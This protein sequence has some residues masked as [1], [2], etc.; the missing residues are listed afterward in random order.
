MNKTLRFWLE[1]VSRIMNI[2]TER[3]NGRVSYK[4]WNP[5]WCKRRLFSASKGWRRLHCT[6]PPSRL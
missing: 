5:Y 4:Y 3:T 6:P 1:I 2:K